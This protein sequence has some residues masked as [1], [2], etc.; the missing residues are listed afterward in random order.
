MSKVN[1]MTEFQFPRSRLLIFCK[2]PVVGKVKTRLIPALGAVAATSLHRELASRL[3]ACCQTAMLAPIQ[4]WC[5][6]D[7][8]HEFFTHSGLD[9]RQQEGANLGERMSHALTAALSEPGVES[10]I[11]IGTDCVNL[12]AD[13]LQRAFLRLQCAD[14]VLGPA[15]DGGYGLIGLSEPAPAVFQNLAWGTAAVCAGTAQHFNA[16]FANWDLLPMLWDVD[17]PED[18]E[19]YQTLLRRA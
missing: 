13:Y 9:C 19:R 3:M 6:P 8:T 15:E 5:A 10:A 2:A 18:V 12:D 4:L 1:N 17:R 14:A 11:L 16:Q 7:I